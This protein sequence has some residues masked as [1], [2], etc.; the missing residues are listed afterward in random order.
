MKKKATLQVLLVSVTSALQPVSAVPA[1]SA[2]RTAAQ[3]NGVTFTYRVVGDGWCNW[4]DSDGYVVN[5][6][7]DGSWVYLCEEGEE[8]VPSLCRVA[9]EPPPANALKA[10]RMRRLKQRTQETY[11]APFLNRIWTASAWTSGKSA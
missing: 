1:Y 8:M 10:E 5:T 6:R 4:L 2:L 3:P 7:S 9:I 11:A